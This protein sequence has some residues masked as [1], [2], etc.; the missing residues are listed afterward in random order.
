MSFKG[1]TMLKGDVEQIDKVDH[2]RYSIM[3]IRQ[4]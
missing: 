1:K 3:N 2:A 4:P